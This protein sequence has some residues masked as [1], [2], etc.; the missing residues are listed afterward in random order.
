MT[1]IKSSVSGKL[2]EK[3]ISREKNWA[4]SVRKIIVE[5]KSRKLTAGEVTAEREKFFGRMAKIFGGDKERFPKMGKK[6]IVL[7]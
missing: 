3:T 1:Q 7:G 2:R 6:F 4:D 5:R